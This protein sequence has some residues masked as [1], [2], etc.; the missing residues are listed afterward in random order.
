MI[1]IDKLEKHSKNIRKMI[2]KTAKLS[3]TAHYG[4]CL[5]C[6]DIMAYIFSVLSIK[7]E[8]ER[9]RFILSKGHC[10]L[11]LYA[12]LK[13]FDYITQ[14]ELETFNQ[15]GGDFPSHCVK[16]LAKGIELSSGS[17]GMGLSF[18]TGQALALKMR[19]LSNKI[20]VLAGNGEANEGS[21]WESVMYIGAKQINNIILFLDNNKMQNDGFSENVLPVNN[22]AERFESFGW[23]AISIDGHDYSQIGA[24]ENYQNDKPMAV[25]L[26]T[27][28]GKGISFM[29]NN[30]KWHH[31]GIS[32]DEYEQ[33]LK[34]LGDF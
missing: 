31:S 13:E 4:G 20:Y 27:I 19:N 30:D 3:P 2:I 17:L 7:N 26:N 16:N 12:A 15:N 6:A 23:N 9:D 14:D 11:A 18:A 33:A 8:I 34:E 28:K 32:D 21:F 10:A 29:E 24:I 22:W 25:V 1:D 5:S